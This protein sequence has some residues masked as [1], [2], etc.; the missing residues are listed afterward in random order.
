MLYPAELRPPSEKLPKFASYFVAGPRFFF[1]VWIHT[2]QKNLPRALYL[3]NLVA[4]LPHYRIGHTSSLLGR[5]LV[6]GKLS[7]FSLR[8]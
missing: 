3:T 8:K 2:L 4:F 1:T 6:A 5:F 7:R